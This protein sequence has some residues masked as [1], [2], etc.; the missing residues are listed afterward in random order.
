M[1]LANKQKAVIFLTNW[2][3]TSFS[4]RSLLHWISWNW[5][6]GIYGCQTLSCLTFSFFASEHI[7]SLQVI[8]I[9]N[10]LKYIIFAMLRP[11][12]VNLQ[13]ISVSSHRRHI[14]RCTQF[15]DMFRSLWDLHQVNIKFLPPLSCYYPLRVLPDI[16][17]SRLN[18]EMF[19]SVQFHAD[20]RW[21]N[22]TELSC[23]AV[24]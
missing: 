18:P 4:R 22:L 15:R 5:R 21:N 7:R 17:F 19:N 6:R 12:C 14:Y 10:Q 1:Q 23:R 9:H 11:T 3:A 13:M 2:A 16:C 24:L 8:A 20:P